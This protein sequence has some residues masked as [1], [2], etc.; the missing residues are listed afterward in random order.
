MKELMC[1]YEQERNK[2]NKLGQKSLEAGIPLGSNN[3]VQEQ[4]RKVDRLIALIYQVK[5]G[6]RINHYLSCHIG[7]DNLDFPAW[8]LQALRGRLDDVSARIE[9]NPE[10][11]AA[12]EEE[13]KA[14]QTLQ[15]STDLGRMPEFANWEDKHH[16][17]QAILYERLYWQGIK[18]GVQLASALNFSTIPNEKE[19]PSEAD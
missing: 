19:I 16:C 5:L 1:R 6:H 15:A 2:L 13:R 11:G 7:G 10:F 18:D 9:H 8:I 12:S 17:K 14:F 4:S 3:E